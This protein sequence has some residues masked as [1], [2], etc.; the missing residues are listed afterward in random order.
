ML[1]VSE[2]AKLVQK[3]ILKLHDT[4]VDILVITYDGPES[5]ISMMK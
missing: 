1:Y 4:N 3:A 5:H 2:K